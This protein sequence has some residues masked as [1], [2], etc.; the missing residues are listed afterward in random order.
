MDVRLRAQLATPRSQLAPITLAAIAAAW[1]WALPPMITPLF[2]LYP[3]NWTDADLVRHLWRFRLVRP[4]WVG[5][6]PQYDYLRWAQAETLARLTVG[7][8]GWITGA[9]LILR[10]HFCGRIV[11][12]PNPPLQWTAGFV[13][14]FFFD[15]LGPPPLSRFVRRDPYANLVNRLPRKRAA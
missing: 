13:S 11:P 2:Y 6:P 3:N 1:F 7:L 10:R 9:A 4:E 14:L 12:R 5:R 8:L 15:A